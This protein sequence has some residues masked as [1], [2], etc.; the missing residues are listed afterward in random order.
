MSLEAPVDLFERPFA[1]LTLAELHAEMLTYQS[2][3]AHKP[4]SAHALID[5]DIQLVQEEIELQ[6][7]SA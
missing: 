4:P 7:A 2:E 3:K 5:E 1:D 6:E